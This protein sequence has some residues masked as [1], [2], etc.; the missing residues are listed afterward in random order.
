MTYS[1]KVKD[2]SNNFIGEFDKFRNLKFGKRINNYGSMAFEVPLNDPKAESLVGLR[3]YSVWVYRDGD[4]IWSGEQVMRQS[5]LT[6]KGDN[7]ATIYCF[8]WF[9][10]L[11]GRHTG[12]T[13]T[14]TA[15][16]AG[17]IA[18]TL[19]DETQTDSDFGIT[20][21]TIEV[22]MDRDVIYENQNIAEAIT[23]LSNVINGFD[24]EVSDTKVFNVFGTQGVDRTELIFEYG[25]NITN[26]T[27]SE[28]FAHPANRAIILGDSGVVSDPLRVERDDAGSQTQYKLREVVSNEMNTV[29]SA[30]LEEKGDALLRKYGSPLF[31]ISMDLVRSSFPTI[32]DFALGDIVTLK[33]QS[34]IYNIEDTYRIYEW[35]IDYDENDT[36]KLDLVLAK[37]IIP[38]FS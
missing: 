20:Q 24:F 17:N 2:G 30:T 7:W 23:N 18:W 1:L 38:E 3:I 37:F 35:S 27:I 16:D 5:K 28:D 4:L 11:A 22:T 19:I 9:E 21:G 25:H 31:K 29:E 12:A 34:G 36:E 6:D 26:I 32:A 8:T 13:R 10:Q 15:E 33:V 14:F